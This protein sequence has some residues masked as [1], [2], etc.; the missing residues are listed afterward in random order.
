MTVDANDE[1]LV[2]CR[3]FIQAADL[4]EERVAARLGIGRSD[5][6]AVNLLENGPIAQGAIAR[7]LGLT[8]PTVTALI[9]RLE[10]H[11]L[12]RRTPHPTDRRVT[13]VELLPR[14]WGQLAGI[15]L[16]IG[17]AVLDAAA[18]LKAR[19]R[20]HMVI[21]LHQWAETFDE[22]PG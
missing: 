10:T 15:Y 8:P 14:A 6:R 12:V 4:C 11:A 2:A 16:P 22:Q 21:V 7:E 3:R 13:L 9:D 20:A 19:E 5:L 17:G 18:R 1:L